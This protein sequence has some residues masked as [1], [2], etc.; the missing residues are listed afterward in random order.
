MVKRSLRQNPE[1]PDSVEV[2]LKK[3]K[4]NGLRSGDFNDEARQGPRS[5]GWRQCKCRTASTFWKLDGY[6]QGEVTSFTTEMIWVLL[7]VDP[8]LLGPG[9]ERKEPRGQNSPAENKAGAASTSEGGA[10]LDAED[11]APADA[12][13]CPQGWERQRPGLC[14]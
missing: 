14:W 1:G 8:G 7:A 13:A 6:G 9:E 12:A 2:L 11:Q 3:E 4:S 5:E 10:R